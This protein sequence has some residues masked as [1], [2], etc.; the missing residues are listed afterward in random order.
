MLNGEVIMKCI[1]CNSETELTSS[2]IIT[3]AI[4]GAKLTKSFVCKTHNAL[5][6]DKYEKQFVADLDFFRNHLGLTTRDG[7]PIQYKADITVDGIEMHNVK[8][9]NRESL[10]APKEVVTGVDGDGKKV[11]MAPMDKIEKISKGKA[12]VVDISDVVLHKT[13]SS[14]SF[15]GFH[16]IHSIAKMAYEWYCYKNNIEEFKEEYSDIVSYILGKADGDFVDKADG[17]F[18]DIIIDGNYYFAMDKLSEIGTNS[19]F[20]YDDVDG[21]RYV[22]VDLW[23]TVSYRV[24]IG[25]SSESS[26]SDANALSF[27]LYLYHIDGSK[28]KTV[29]GAYSL[30][31]N[32]RPAFYTVQPQNMTA[33]IWRVFVK[34][35]EKIMSTMVLSIQALKREVDGLSSKLKKY[36]AGTIDVARLLGFEENNVVT[37]IDIIN[38]LH[39]NKDKYDATKSFNQNLPTIL[40]LDS[41]T[42]A[43][44]QEDKMEFIKSLVTMDKENKL[45]EYIWNGI[46][47]F[48]K[49]YENEMN[50]TK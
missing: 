22:V 28:S 25:K 40:N 8:V 29:F 15:L 23:K 6:N 32:K 21:Y 45:S 24:R 33:E 18:V 36:D 7:K 42:I 37:T 41:D 5:T 9:S 26:F 49:I 13:I 12:S 11:L 44:T 43:R 10:Y 17:D 47:T 4:T 2:D 46:Y 27:E 34:R 31:P 3:Y 16:A 50:L 35:I 48:N 19:F 1:Y 20:Q 30:D 38:Q 14:D 39:L